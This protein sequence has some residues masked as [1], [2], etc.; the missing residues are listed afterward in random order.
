MPALRRL[1]SIKF[2]SIWICTVRIAIN[3][4]SGK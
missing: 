1:A 4:M 3:R 2:I